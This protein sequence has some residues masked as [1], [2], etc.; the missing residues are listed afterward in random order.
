MRGF[1]DLSLAIRDCSKFTAKHWKK[2]TPSGCTQE[3]VGILRSKNG[4]E[5]Q[6]S[7]MDGSNAP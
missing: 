6:T 4:A 2:E 7:G 5:D 3:G 1:D